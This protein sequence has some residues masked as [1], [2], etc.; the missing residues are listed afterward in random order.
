[1]NPDALA[2]YISTC[3]ASESTS[4][5]AQLLQRLSG[6]EVYFNMSADGQRSMTPYRMGSL[7]CVLMFYVS[8]QDPKLRA[9]FAGI[10]W[11][12][13]L[14]ICFKISAVQGAAIVNT[15]D[16][17]VVFPRDQITRWLTEQGEL[18]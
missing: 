3:V 17:W 14:R 12:E 5:Y 18:Q 15:A 16:D 2:A 9:P 10:L 11:Q 1:M 13:G 8:N 7:T 4:D 6:T